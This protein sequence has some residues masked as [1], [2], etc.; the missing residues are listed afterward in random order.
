MPV[1]G[2]SRAELTI[3]L[4]MSS[5]SS[6]KGLVSHVSSPM[7]IR[8]TSKKKPP[9]QAPTSASS[10]SGA[11]DLPYDVFHQKA[12]CDGG[13]AVFVGHGEGEEL[14]RLEAVGGGLEDDGWVGGWGGGGG[15]VA[16]SCATHAACC[17]DKNAS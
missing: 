7:A 14:E 4:S 16:T 17:G 10:R 9:A 6:V 12:K 15:V 13:T 11:S 8:E 5:N 3:P 1:A 2:S